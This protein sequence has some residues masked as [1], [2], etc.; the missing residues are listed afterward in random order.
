[1]ILAP[2]SSGHVC[3]HRSRQ[4]RG[5]SA[6][7]TAL[8]CLPSVLPAQAAGGPP[9]HRQ[10]TAA[11]TVVVTPNARYDAG[12]LQRWL[13]G[14]HYRDLWATPIEVEVL[15]LRTFAGGLQ[16]T[17]RGGSMQTKSL[18]FKG[19]DG[20]EYVFRPIDKDLAPSLPSELRETLVRQLYQDQTSSFHPAAALVVARL[21][22]ATGIRHVQPRMVSLPDD[23][24]LGEFRGEYAKQLGTLEERPGRGFDEGTDASGAVDVISS[25]RLFDKMRKSPDTR[26]DTRAY[27]AARLFDV[28]VGDRDRHRDQWRWATFREGSGA[29][30]EPVPRD[31]DFAFV[32]HD[33]VL[34]AVARGWYPQLVSFDRG[35]PAME[36]LNWNGR[37]IDRRLLVGLERPVWD[38][39]ARDLQ[40]R[41][42]DS[43]IVASVAVMP[44][45]FTERNGGELRRALME[46][47]DHLPAA[48]GALYALLAREV[49]LRA[50]DQCDVAHVTRL[51]DGSVDVSLESSK[52]AYFR[53][54][55]NARETKEVRIFLL[56]GDD[57]AIVRGSAATGVV[58][59]V[60]GGDGND[61]LI[62]STAGRHTRFYDAS[63]DDRIVSAARTRIDRRPYTPPATKRAQDP[64]RDWGHEWRP[65]PWIDYGPDLGVFLGFGRT[66]YD[67]GF[68]YDPYVSRMTLQAG[69]ALGARRAKALFAG[70]FH[71]MNSPQYATLELGA[72]G[73]EVLRFYGFGNETRIDQPDDFYRVVHTE[74]LVDPAYVLPLS[75]SISVALGAVA[76]Y[77]KTEE[78]DNTLVGTTRPYGSGSFA[79][80]GPRLGLT[81]DTR[82]RVI[83]TR[84]GL[85]VATSATL[86]PQVGD[87]ERAFGEAHGTAAAYLGASLPLEPTLALRVGGQHL[88]GSFPFHEAAFLGGRSTLRGW[89]EQR[90]AG[91]SSLYGNA[92]LRLFVTRFFLFVPSDLG[93]FGLADGGRVYAAG[94]R[95]S[96]WHTAFGGGVWV[97]PLK[98]RNT[99][100]IAFARGRERSGM[101]VRSGF[102]F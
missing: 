2:Y 55:F 77:T 45:S 78:D 48:A 14:A 96:E 5:L 73:I 74:Y 68:R 88:W 81:L 39:V 98:R 83:A 26:I 35:Y 50:S 1:M 102:L 21:L 58:V 11:D 46:R 62:D 61:E 43:V 94:E 7:V 72:S 42:T 101:Y 6:I 4:V 9:R 27:L 20:K 76:R 19:A 12:W 38:S 28:V 10:R 82:D 84:R 52:G 91:R 80:V 51:D 92:E 29:V 85:H 32:K 65:A 97:A 69:Y 70:E 33:G 34:L 40:A 90:F 64:P 67:Y 23:P 44:Q 25:E 93:V 53:R 31:R 49:D 15:D 36:G 37:E 41:L 24:L 75:R 60:I 63:G 16:P 22:D 17:Q 18:R 47:R 30:W 86:Y 3:G 56:D 71:R 99:V 59:R 87:V 13:L 66:R 100:S 8:A 95:S 79:E 89:D 57:R 54:H